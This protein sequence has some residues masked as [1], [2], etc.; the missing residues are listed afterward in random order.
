[1]KHEVLDLFP[2]SVLKEKILLSSKEKQKLVEHILNTEKETENI[3]KRKYDA[4][5][6]DSR[7]HEFFLKNPNIVVLLR[8]D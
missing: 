3:K 5:L 8:R 2:L 4:W 1:M 7:G 6:G